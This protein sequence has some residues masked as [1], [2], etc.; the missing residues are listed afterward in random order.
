MGL[1]AVCESCGIKMR[2]VM[3]P[4]CPTQDAAPPSFKESIHVP[5]VTKICI[6]NYFIISIS[7]SS[8]FEHSKSV[9]FTFVQLIT[10]IRCYFRMA[11]AGIIVCGIFLVCVPFHF[12]TRLPCHMAAAPSTSRMR[13]HL[14]IWLI[15]DPIEIC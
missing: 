5:T 3:P 7:F 1:L 10:Q 4:Y 2:V 9:L 12:E 6:L 13:R 8:Q 14:C 11:F 15:H